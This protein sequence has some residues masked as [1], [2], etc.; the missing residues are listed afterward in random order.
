VNDDALLLGID[1]GTG[2][3]KGVL[4]D[5]AGTPVATAVHPHRTDSPRPGWFEHDPETVWWQG[6]VALA[7]QLLAGIEPHRVVAMGVSGIGPCALIADAGGAPLRQAILYGIDTRATAEIER[8][9]AELTTAEILRACGNPLTTQAVGP[10][11]AWLA[12]HEPTAAA[13]ARRWFSCSSY[14]AYRLTGRYTADHYTASVSDPLYDLRSGTWWPDGW[15]ACAP[16]I[17]PPELA[18]PGDVVGHLDAAAAESTGLVAGTPVLSCGVDAL[19]ESYS[20]GCREP[21][22]TMVMYGS[23]LFFIQ[24]LDRPV[25]DPRLWA[26]VGR[27]RGTHALAAGMST[28][29]LLA[30][31]FADVIERD[32]GA[33]AEE[34]ATVPAG[35]DGLVLLPYLAGE[36]TP[37]EDPAASGCWLGLTLRHTR[38]HLFRSVLE[39]VGYGVRHNLETMDD[40][41]A[42]PGRLFA[43][44][45]GTAGGLWTGIVS[46][47]TGRPQ[48]I[49]TLTI[50]ASYGDARMAADAV[51]ID[52]T[53]WNP[54]QRVVEPDRLTTATYDAL[55]RVYRRLYPDVRD[56]MHLLAA[57]AS[58]RAA[59]R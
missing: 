56:A 2:S 3:S 37:I 36:R 39:G 34:A 55:Y 21:G 51:G 46:S 53:G 4:V 18:W 48:I 45:G 19:A 43:V 14:I 47:I 6:T 24:L 28:G 59:G 11:L 31:W 49:P 15:Q 1:I 8:M 50:G 20:A 41:G 38:A 10:K 9:T 35:S 29:G 57:T 40:A 17:R 12:A 16:G 30:T 22:D 25:T 58:T 32:V 27:E 52:T 7:R 42:R 13:A 33:A 5:T 44:G 54:A 23:T 26:A